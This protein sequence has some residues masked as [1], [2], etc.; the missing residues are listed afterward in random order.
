MLKKNFYAIFVLVIYMKEKKLEKKIRKST[1]EK[2]Y[3]KSKFILLECYIKHF[4]KMLKY[5]HENID[6]NWYMYDYLIK[7]KDVYLD[8]YSR[9]IDKMIEVLY[10]NNYDLK[11]QIVWLIENAEIF[12]DYKL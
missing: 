11:G 5:K 9:D 2:N 4:R 6:N 8:Y 10:S 3:E 1:K 7:I 12:N